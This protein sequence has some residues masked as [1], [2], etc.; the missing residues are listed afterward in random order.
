MDY[1]YNAGEHQAYQVFLTNKEVELKQ[2]IGDSEGFLST[3]SDFR[4]DLDINL[5]P[6]LFLKSVSA[7]VRITPFPPR[8]N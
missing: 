7:E 2:S 3:A 5:A 6:L 1:T 8:P 4:Y